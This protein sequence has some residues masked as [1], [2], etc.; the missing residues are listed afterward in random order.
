MNFNNYSQLQVWIEENRTK[1]DKAISVTECK[2]W[3]KLINYN[4]TP[5][6]CVCSSRNPECIFIE[7]YYEVMKTYNLIQKEDVCA[8]AIMEYNKIKDNKNAIFEWVKYYEGL[9]K[10]VLHFNPII[11][12]KI[13]Q[14][15]YKV[16]QIVLPESEL[17]SLL[18][19]KDIF[20][21]FYY[22]EEYVNY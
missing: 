15:P 19:F 9:G 10:K 8:N 7:T 2:K 16:E 6:P 3:D 12:I 4:E 1:N 5:F 22:S 20:T 17:K 14:E 18:E 21:E 11:T 13:N